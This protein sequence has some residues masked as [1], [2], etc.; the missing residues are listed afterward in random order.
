MTTVKGYPEDEL[1][2]TLLMG[3][4]FREVRAVFA[5]EDWSGLRQ[6]HFRRDL[7]G[8]GGGDQRHRPR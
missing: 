7:L 1:H 5:T 6:S 2:A 4:L 8:A 3:L